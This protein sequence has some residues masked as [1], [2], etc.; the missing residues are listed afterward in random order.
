LPLTIHSA[1]SP[2]VAQDT[3]SKRRRI[4]VRRRFGNEG[5]QSLIEFALCLPPLF[6]LL[7]G[8]VALGITFINY[9]Q[10]SNAADNAATQLS[11][12]RAGV[13]ATVING[14]TTYDPCAFMVTQVE[15]AAPSLKP[16][17]M[18]FSLV[19]NG[20]SYPGTKGTGL[21]CSSTSLTSGASLIL[22]KAFTDPVTVT[23]K[24]PCE[25]A[26]N[27]YGTNALFNCTLT[28]SMTEVV[29]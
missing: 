10:L 14:N 4:R 25:L 17:S 13:P 24:Y 16:A 11:L 12:S 26:I 2:E 21:N 15:N 28:A 18:T 5:G 19:I 9:N 7:T 29:Q 22:S 6:V 20:T 8:F 1:P 23:V 27:L 3:C